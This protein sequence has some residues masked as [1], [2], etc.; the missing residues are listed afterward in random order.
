MQSLGLSIHNLLQAPNGGQT[1]QVKCRAWTLPHPLSALPLP[2][3]MRESR[4]RPCQLESL[5]LPSPA[6]GWTHRTSLPCTTLQAQRQSASSSSPRAFRHGSMTTSF[7]GWRGLFMRTPRT[8]LPQSPGRTCSCPAGV[9]LCCT[10]APMTRYTSESELSSAVLECY[11]EAGCTQSRH[12]CLHTGNCRD[13][14]PRAAVLADTVIS[15]TVSPCRGLVNRHSSPHK[16]VSIDTGLWRAGARAR[17][18]A[19]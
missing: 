19:S 18:R 13:S 17:R 2:A 16:H 1:L 8:M 15:D 11:H 14:L 5:Y 4:T 9:L 10:A 12:E 7:E 6:A 3:R